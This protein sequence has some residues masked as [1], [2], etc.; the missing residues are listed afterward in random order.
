[1]TCHLFHRNAQGQCFIISFEEDAPVYG[2]PFTPD[3]QVFFSNLATNE[4]HLNSHYVAHEAHSSLWETHIF[5]KTS[6]ESNVK[7]KCHLKCSTMND[8][9]INLCEFLVV[10]G[11]DC[12][13]GLF[14]HV[15]GE[16]FITPIK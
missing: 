3:S 5:E 2:G 4:E 15:R 1:T 7:R 10:V 9:A 11:N 14:S 16:P 13:L 6:L 12:H 8:Y